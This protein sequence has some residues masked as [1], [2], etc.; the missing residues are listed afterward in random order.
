MKGFGRLV[1]CAV[2]ALA[3]AAAHS[4]A[5]ATQ[6]A[7]ATTAGSDSETGWYCPMHQGYTAADAGKCPTCGMALIAGTPFD[8]RDYE[9]DFATSPAAVASGIPF[10]MSFRVRHP[11]TGDTVKNYEV[12]H[13][14]QFHLFVVSQDLT[15]FQ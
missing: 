15:E 2:V 3:F 12:V 9:L 10:T 11:G 1:A 6:A 4:F 7:Q 8:T 13:D 5:Q 14:K